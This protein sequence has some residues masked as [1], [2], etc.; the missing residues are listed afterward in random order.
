MNHWCYRV[1]KSKVNYFYKELL[2]G[3]LRQGWGWD[4]RQDLRNFQLD[5]GAGRNRPMFS[6]VKKG[7]VIL[8]PSLPTIGE[9]ALVRATEDWDKGYRFEIDSS[10][11]DYGHIF[12]AEYIKSFKRGNQNV[13]GNLRSTLKNM[14][15][16]W[17][18]N[19]YATD[20]QTLIATEQ[21]E[22]T[23]VQ[24]H[25][26]RLETSIDSVFNEVFNG[27]DFADRLYEKLTNQF[28]NEE[29]EYALIYGLKKL[30]P[31]YKIERVGGKLEKDHGTDILVKIPGVLPDSEYAIAIQVK[32][33]EGLVGT[34]VVDQ[35]NKSELYW[36]NDN[37][38]LIERIVIVIRADRSN[39]DNLINFD[40]NIKFIFA[41]ELKQ[42]L[43]EIG[44]KFIG[45]K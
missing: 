13:T 28:S 16:F 17:N 11:G 44:K 31:I 40:K 1:D 3:R 29:W 26:S 39:H 33:Y 23:K 22:L 37:I 38:K 8:V 32:D 24:D 41:A 36:D 10:L 18:I 30:Y 4:A 15:R 42:L 27:S 7:D 6:K 5:E 45:M 19:H 14:S 34:N 21:S 2:E 12:P 9:V 43:L 20:V 35:I 25:K